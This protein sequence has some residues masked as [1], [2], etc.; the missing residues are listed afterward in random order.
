MKRGKWKKYL[1]I[2]GIAIVVIII[3][4]VGVRKIMN[5]NTKESSINK[6][7][8][9]E[10]DYLGTTTLSMINSLNNLNLEDVGKVIMQTV[11]R[12]MHQKMKRK[13]IAR[14]QIHNSKK[15]RVLI[16]KQTKQVVQEPIR[17][18]QRASRLK[19]TLYY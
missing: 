4:I 8:N 16:Q 9:N 11:H 19:T 15:T 13:I 17:K 2:A 6:K 14:P 3:A 5:N 12:E 18:I 1:I 10:L 7:I